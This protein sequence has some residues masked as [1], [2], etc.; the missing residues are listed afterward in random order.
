MWDRPHL[1][2]R[3]CAATTAAAVYDGYWTLSG[4]KRFNEST[5]DSGKRNQLLRLHNHNIIL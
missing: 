5:P 2:L 1:D 3:K 4:G